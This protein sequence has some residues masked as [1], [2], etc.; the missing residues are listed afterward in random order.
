MGGIRRGSPVKHPGRIHPAGRIIRRDAR[1]RLCVPRARTKRVIACRTSRATPAEQMDSTAS[2]MHFSVHR[3]E[4]AFTFR[5][6][7][8]SPSHPELFPRM[9]QV[10]TRLNLPLNARA[11]AHSEPACASAK[12]G[13]TSLIYKCGSRI[14]DLILSAIKSK[15]QRRDRQELA[16][17]RA[18]VVLRG[19]EQ[20]RALLFLKSPHWLLF[21]PN[22]S[23]I[24]MKPRQGS[25]PL[26]A[27]WGR[28]FLAAAATNIRGSNKS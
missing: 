3:T 21:P 6:V 19:A 17:A 10:G 7:S 4:H 5:T 8:A 1:T 27:L 23:V 28:W 15:Q 24:Q 12:V 22:G 26:T 20:R 2:I 9:K 18:R 13:G 11:R 14:K 16:R 25:F